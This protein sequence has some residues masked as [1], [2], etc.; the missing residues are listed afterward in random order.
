MRI[1]QLKG[2]P[3]VE[4]SLSLKHQQRISW[5][6][7]QVLVVCHMLRAIREAPQIQLQIR[8]KFPSPNISSPERNVRFW[9]KTSEI[10]Y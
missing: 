8:I 9:I 1:R 5:N 7:D 4:L 2:R 10:I 6:K 3:T